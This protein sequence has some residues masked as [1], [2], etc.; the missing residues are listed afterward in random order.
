MLAGVLAYVALIAL[1]AATI[2]S[3]GMAMTRLTIERMTRPY[4]SSGYQRAAASLQQT[5]AA[6]MQSG[7]V[8]YP[9]P[10]FTPIPAACANSTCTYLTAE[11]ITLTQEAPATPGPACDASQTNCAPN[12]QTNS[13]VAESRLTAQITVNILDAQGY[14]IATRTGT[15]LLRTLKS[16]PYVAIAG[17]R[18]G[19][20]DDV[21]NAANA[22]DDG[23]APPATPNPCAASTLSVSDDTAVRVEYRNKNT[24]ACTDGSAWGN[25][26]YGARSNSSGWSP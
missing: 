16:P 23:G 19:A 20:F 25:S 24:N 13:Y 5:V 1:V 9:A 7:G 15:V 17:A 4:F 22:G 2:L 18:D 21:L 6:D 26:S 3:A 11:T 14:S 12:V 8:P 10:T